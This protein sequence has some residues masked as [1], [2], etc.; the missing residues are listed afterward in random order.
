MS[1]N[2][3]Y[4]YQHL[5][6]R[7]RRDDKGLLLKRFLQHF[8]VKLDQYDEV[9][10]TFSERIDPDTATAEWI[11]FWMLV[12]FEW[13][14]FPWWFTLADKRRVYGNFARHLARRG[15]AV[16]I[17]TF[18]RDFG[19]VARVDKR[20]Q[21]WGEF[22]WG[23]TGFSV[24]QPLYLV[25][26]ILRIESP[27]TDASFVGEGVWGE[28]IYTRPRRPFT[29]ADIARLIRYQQVA[30]QVIDVVWKLGGY[31]PPSDDQVWQQIQW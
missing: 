4:L 8:G 3:E 6:A 13:S 30:G 2:L 1:F 27:R 24:P 5:P 21:T 14:W 31:V 28:S 10:D 17:E 26:E 19:I 7:F 12:L 11:A 22:V 23:E 29:D 9:Y 18:L 20:P 16:G 25:V 15:T